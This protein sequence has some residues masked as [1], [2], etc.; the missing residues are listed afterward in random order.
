MAS[1]IDD[2]SHQDR[3]I[4]VKLTAQKEVIVLIELWSS[5]DILNKIQSS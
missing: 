2:R 4:R 1:S 3:Q 5:N